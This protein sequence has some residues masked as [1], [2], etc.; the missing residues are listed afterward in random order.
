MDKSK[1]GRGIF[2]LCIAL[3][4]TVAI[5]FSLSYIYDSKEKELKI[6]EKKVLYSENNDGFIDMYINIIAED[7]AGNTYV[8]KDEY[9]NEIEKEFDGTCSPTSNLYPDIDC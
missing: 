8:I 5:V 6:V 7:N 1:T 3:A 2:V 9:F 4:I